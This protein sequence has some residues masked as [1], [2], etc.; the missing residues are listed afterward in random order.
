MLI[1]I[2][3]AISSY[4]LEGRHPGDDGAIRDT[5]T[6]DRHADVEVVVVMQVVDGVGAGMLVPPVA[7]VYQLIVQS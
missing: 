3:Y 1:Y 4:V 2:N 5:A 6:A 7:V